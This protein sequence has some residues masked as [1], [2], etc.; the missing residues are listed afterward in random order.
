MTNK[1]FSLQTFLDYSEQLRANLDQHPSVIGLVF[2]GS[3]ADPSRADEWS[4]HDFF[5]ITAE[6]F[7]E[8]L[9]QNVEW[10]PNFESVEIAVR[11]TDHGLKVVY[12]DG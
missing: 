5:V 4:D 6:G 2:L 3:A 1:P 8:S 7:A 10:L 11:E 9:R 12:Q